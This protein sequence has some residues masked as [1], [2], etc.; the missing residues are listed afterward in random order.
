MADT[1]SDGN[2]CV[3]CI[4]IFVFFFL[5]VAI[6]WGVPVGKSKWNVDIFPPRI[7]DM[8]AATE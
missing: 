2:G 5:V 1:S 4:S 6:G 3:G 7:W 8:K